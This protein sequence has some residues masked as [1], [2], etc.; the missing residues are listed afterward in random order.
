VA[1]SWDR[2]A[3]SYLQD[4]LPVQN[5]RCAAGTL[6]L[7]ATSY[8]QATISKFAI[9]TALR[10]FSPVKRKLGFP[11]SSHRSQ[12]FD[13]ARMAAS[14]GKQTFDIYQHHVYTPV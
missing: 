14:G 3:G 11:E 9:L 7:Q 8:L 1:V 2:K 12:R 4:I 5:C 6:S 10:Q 13:M